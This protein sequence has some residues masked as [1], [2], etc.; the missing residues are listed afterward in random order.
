MFGLGSF[1]RKRRLW[2]N[3]AALW[4][5]NLARKVADRLGLQIVLKSYY[6]PIPDLAALPAGAWDRRDQLRG[7]SFD[8]QP[9]LELLEQA[10]SH[11]RELGDR[12]D[13]A[14]GHAF[15]DQNPSYPLCDARVLYA[16]V[17]HLRP[18]RI[19]ELGSGQTTRLLAQA[20]RRNEGEGALTELRAYDPFPTAVD[21]SLPG[22]ARLERIRAQDVPDAVFEEL[23]SGDLL[24]VDTTHTVKLGGDVNDIVLR[25]LPLLAPGV[26]VH[27]HDIFLPYEYPRFFFERFGLYWAEQYMLQAFLAFNSAFE[28]VCGVHALGRDEGSRMAAAGYVKRGETGS[29]FWMRRV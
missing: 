8:L 19:V 29:A 13:V 3:P 5:Y 20:A 2:A 15:E 7:V 21:A 11:V 12:D 27:F 1:V 16:L 6:S 25:V 10:R 22:L 26:V 24:F 17:R 14:A 4:L 28:V 18:H 9:Q 23:A